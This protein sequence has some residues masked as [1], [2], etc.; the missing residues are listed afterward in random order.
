MADLVLSVTYFGILL[1]LGIIIANLLKKARVPDTFF[2]LLLGLLLGPT[3]Y[4]NPVVM[5]YIS[6]TLVD[7]SQMGNIPDFLRVL[8][9]IMV[10][11]TGTFNLGMRAFRRFGRLS[12]NIALAGVLF[13]T[14]V[15]GLVAN[16]LFGFELVYSFLMA[17]VVSG[18]CTSVVFAF[19]DSL[20]GARK[21]LGVI[22]VESILNSP[23]SV[24]LPIIF[25]DLVAIE[26]GAIIEPM[27]YLSQFWVMIAVG[28]GAGLIIGLGVGR[29]LKGMLKQYSA[30]MLFA[31]AL[32]TYALAENVG[33]SG[34]LAVAVCGLMAGSHIRQK[35]TDV[36]KFDDHLSEMLRISVFTLLGAQVTLLIGLEE[37]FMILVFFLMMF[38]IRP[39][40]LMPVLGK[41]RKD[42]E[43][44]ELL[45]MSF[46]TPRGLSAAAIAP[47]VAT[48][49]IAAGSPDVAASIMNIIF[50]VI[51]L[52]VL[53][54]TAVALL[55]S[56]EKDKPK[57]REPEKEEP[58]GKSEE[59]FVEVRAPPEQAAPQG[60]AQ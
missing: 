41:K 17:A 35:D 58:E 54:S 18:T 16:M 38:L 56:R 60:P 26:P 45:L 34:M 11:F 4:A 51:M 31:V 21:A 37:F 59:E 57:K 1:G 13:N 25:L 49:L 48:A 6:T 27:R 33:G 20:R 3:L 50:L 40:F 12:V 19:E 2:L 39:V 22:K 29:V 9:L 28:V 36:Q 53:F 46:V 32:V 14:V 15:M 24:L 7:V 30:L 10:V 44:R 23:L 8:A 47:I 5:Q 55:A 42:F 43:R 52:S